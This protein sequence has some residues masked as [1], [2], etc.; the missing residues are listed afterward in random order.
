MTS[1]SPPARPAAS[2]IIA[3]SNAVGAPH[4]L[5]QERASSMHFAGGAL[6]FPGGAVDPAD[7][8]YASAFAPADTLD[9][10]AA[11]IAAVR[12]CIEEC[13]LALAVREDAMAG[14]RASALRQ[15]LKAGG[16]LADATQALGIAF[17]FDRLIPFARWRPPANAVHRRYDT[18]FFLA[19]LDEVPDDIS[20]DGNETVRLVWHSAQEVLDEAEA[21]RAHIIF[22][23]RRNLERL[24]QCESIAALVAHAQAHRADLIEPWVEARDGIEH[25]CIPQGLGYPVT[26]EPLSSARRA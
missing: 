7:R 22:P 12:E 6:V 10:L 4:F 15:A 5:M 13:G 19:V 1:H 25:L 9:D 14:G 24:A 16:T 20:P 8:E 23:T 26:A 17:D 2:V 18:R 11:R 3:R 21:G